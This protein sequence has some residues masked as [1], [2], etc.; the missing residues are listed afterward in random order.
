MNEFAPEPRFCKHG[1]P[2]CKPC[3]DEGIKRLVK[4]VEEANDIRRNSELAPIIKAGFTKKQA[5][6][7]ADNLIPKDG[8]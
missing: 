4:I 7:I 3:L 1:I 2:N 8:N 6:W 5:E